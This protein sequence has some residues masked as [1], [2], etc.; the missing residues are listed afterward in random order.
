MADENKKFPNGWG[1]DE[2]DDY[3]FI[4]D[5]DEDD[6]DSAW[7]SGSPF[8]K[9]ESVTDSNENEGSDNVQ[10]ESSVPAQEVK[11]SENS[12]APVPPV[13]PPYNQGYVIQKQKSNPLFIIVIIILVL[14]IGVL[15]AAIF[16]VNKNKKT[17]D[18]EKSDVNSVDEISETISKNTEND[19]TETETPDITTAA[20]TEINN[21]STTNIA[22][23]NIDTSEAVK[24]T[25]YARY[26]SIMTEAA[27]TLPIFPP[28]IAPISVITSPPKKNCQP[29][30]ITGLSPVEYFFIRTDENPFA[31]VDI[32]TNPSP[33]RLKLSP[34][35]SPLKLM[36]M[37]P[38]NPSTQPIILCS[39]SLSI[40]YISD[41]MSIAI[42]TFAA[43][44]TAAFTP[45]V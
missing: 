31:T 28:Q 39:A 18:S 24:K 37:I 35:L 25:L 1:S 15:C 29:L 20:K 13:N 23:L 14:I 7:G 44:I 41:D 40:L 12:A 10:T 17:N 33:N 42:K 30:S 3:G 45:V 32:N 6:E 26:R 22:D 16:V 38:L 11:T 8:K 36:I 19:N 21:E 27:F 43:T 5:T 9:K 4:D 2:D 34:P